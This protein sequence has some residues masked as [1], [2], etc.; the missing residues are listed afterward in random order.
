MLLLLI[1]C[2]PTSSSEHDELSSQLE[3]AHSDIEQLQSQIEIEGALIHFVFL[4]LK[5]D[6]SIQLVIDEIKK[7]DDIPEVL[8][9]QVGP[10]TDLGDQR[11]MSDY[12]LVME[13][14]FHSTE[15]YEAYQ[16]HP[17]HL[18]LKEQLGGYLAGPPATYDYLK[19]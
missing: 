2:A 18:N 12:E 7:I 3:K 11:A 19:Q 17:I 16:A 14:S 6:A 10:F 4:N 9:L 13:M 5:D 15:D 1:G 8:D